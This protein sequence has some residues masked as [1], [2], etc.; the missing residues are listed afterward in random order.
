VQDRVGSDP[1]PAMAGYRREVIRMGLRAPEP[2]PGF[3]AGIVDLCEE[4]LRRRGR[5]EERFLLP[6]RRRLESR[7]LPA[8]RA[9]ALFR[10][11]GVAGLISGLA[12]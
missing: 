6:I 10:K 12:L 5:A 7:K 2:A 11:G 9:V 4:A 3:L 8:D 1:W